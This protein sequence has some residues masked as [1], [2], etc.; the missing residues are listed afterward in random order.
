MQ[1]ERIARRAP[2]SVDMR[3]ALSSLY[4][5]EGRSGLAEENWWVKRFD[6]SPVYILCHGCQWNI[7]KSTTQG[8]AG[9]IDENMCLRIHLER[10]QYSNPL[11]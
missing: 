11:T 1:M 8:S 4:W 2:G 7:R 3:A 10:L 6:C 5:S 9:G